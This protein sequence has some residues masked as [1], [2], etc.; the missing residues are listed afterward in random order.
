MK[1]VI[2]ENTT[3]ISKNTFLNNKHIKNVTIPSNVKTISDS[4]FSGCEDLE[5]I[6]FEDGVRRLGE[7]AFAKCI[8]LRNVQLPDSVVSLHSGVFMDCCSLESV[9][10]SENLRRNIEKRTFAGC[11]KLKNIVIPAGIN[12]ICSKSFSECSSLETVVFENEDVMIDPDAFEGCGML[13]DDVCQ[14]IASHITKNNVVDVRSR[15]SGAAGRL[16]NFTQRHFVF[17]NVECDSIEGVLQS[18]KCPDKDKQKEI[19]RLHGR[20]AKAAGQE[21]SWTEK[22]VLYWNGTEYPRKSEEY[23]KLLNRLYTAVYEQDEQF[24]E[25]LAFMKLEK[26]DHRMG[27]TD[28]SKTVLTRSEFVQRLRRLIEL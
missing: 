12:R 17:D 18:F 1:A 16:S 19:C 24:R 8:S 7:N 2:D 27:L 14:F 23:Q 11:V 25:D 20:A 4:A 5:T 22:Q 3:T 13:P 28:K 21:Y 9:I 6:F 10:L 15:A 26:I